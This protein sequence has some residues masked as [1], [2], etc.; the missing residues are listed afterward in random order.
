MENPE[1]VITDDPGSISGRH[2]VEETYPGGQAKVELY[3]D[4]LLSLPKLFSLEAAIGEALDKRVWLKSGGF[5]VIEQT[6]A[7]AVIDVN[8]GKYV[9]KRD[10]GE[11]AARINREAAR[12]IL[13]QI[14]LRNLSGIILV[15]FINMNQDVS[16]SSCWL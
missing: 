16:R 15:D 1:K 7:C 13:R 5:L 10:T 14:R 8:S 6:E 3:E 4:R 2:F 9:A 11:M 12:E